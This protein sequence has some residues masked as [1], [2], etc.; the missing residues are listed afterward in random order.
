[1]ITDN[2]AFL[3][4]LHWG[5]FVFSCFHRIIKKKKKKMGKGKEKMDISPHP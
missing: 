5:S 4:F 1:M 2:G 3:H